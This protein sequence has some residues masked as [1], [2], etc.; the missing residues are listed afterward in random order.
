MGDVSSAL[1][2]GTLLQFEDKTYTV[3]P[4]SYKIQGAYEL[5]LWHQAKLALQDMRGWLV[6]EDYQFLL[7]DLHKRKTAG[8]FTFGSDTVAKSLLCLPHVKYLLYLQLKD[9][10]PEATQELAGKM[11]DAKLKD[12]ME[13]LAE[14]NADPTKASKEAQTPTVTS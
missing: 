9:N 11:V 10:H 3:S 5:Y 7:S 2:M 13:A 14:A 8:E 1:G 12:V 4:W 6:P